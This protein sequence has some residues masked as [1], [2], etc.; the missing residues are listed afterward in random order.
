MLW[1]VRRDARLIKGV[2]MTVRQSADVGLSAFCLVRWA[3]GH[4]HVE[5]LDRSP[6]QHTYLQL[7]EVTKAFPA[8]TSSHNN[9]IKLC[10]LYSLPFAV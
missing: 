2:L 6:S 8:C 1:Q 4:G 5:S 10:L 7:E 9:E 3:V